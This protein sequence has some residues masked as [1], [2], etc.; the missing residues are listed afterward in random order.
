[1]ID[2]R[3]RQCPSTRIGY[4]EQIPALT[5]LDRLPMA[6]IAVGLDDG[7]VVYDNPAAADLLGYPDARSVLE[8]SLPALMASSGA[9]PRDCVAEL[10][11]AHHADGSI[12]EWNHADGYPVRTVTSNSILVRDD[13]PVL[14]VGLVD[15]TELVWTIGQ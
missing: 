2:R 10:V 7:A 4:I 11:A 3:L 9:T 8:R 13:D 1:M 14:L 6:V 12:T 15:V 5:L